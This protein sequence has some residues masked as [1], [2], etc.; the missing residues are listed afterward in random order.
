MPFSR[1]M[2]EI[3]LGMFVVQVSCGS[4]T[5]YDVLTKCSADNTLRPHHK[6]IFEVLWRDNISWYLIM[7]VVR[8]VNTWAKQLISIR[9]AVDQ[10]WYA[11][12]LPNPL[13]ST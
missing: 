1:L 7:M 3:I 9:M 12:S 10:E 2:E 4:G 13:L 11:A 6:N 8:I 5:R